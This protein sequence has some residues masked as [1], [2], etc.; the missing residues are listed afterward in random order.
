M[1]IG[2]PTETDVDSE[3]QARVPKPQ[4]APRAKRRQCKQI[5]R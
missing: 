3:G 5:N 2:A 4:V 1:S